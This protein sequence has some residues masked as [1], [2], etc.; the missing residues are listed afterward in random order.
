LIDIALVEPEIAQNAGSVARLC[1]ATGMK[2]HL[3]GRLGFALDDASLRRAGLDYWSEVCVGVHKDFESFLESVDGRGL[4]LY[5]AKGSRLYTEVVHRG[6]D[7]LIFGSE[8]AGLA[9]RILDE[10][11]DRVLRLP[12]RPGVRSLNLAAVVHVAAFHA[13]AQLGFP[14]IR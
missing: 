8:S 2:L 12:V 4:Y 5:S 10:C 14:G 1:A 13:L 11:C 6:D 9:S 7:V 3:V